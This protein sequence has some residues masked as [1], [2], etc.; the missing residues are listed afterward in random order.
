[1]SGANGSNAGLD[2]ICGMPLLQKLIRFFIDI[3]P[4]AAILLNELFYED[5]GLRARLDLYF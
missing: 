3:F 2:R 1:M 5:D 4:S